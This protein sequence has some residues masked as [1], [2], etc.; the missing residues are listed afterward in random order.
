MMLAVSLAYGGAA[1]GI[2][3]LPAD[4]L[5]PMSAR[6]LPLALAALGLLLGLALCVRGLDVERDVLRNVSVA[7][8]VRAAGLLGLCVL[9][10]LAIEPL[11][12][13]PGGCLAVV[14]GLLLLGER[15]PA[16]LLGLPI[17]A[18]GLLWLVLEG[19][20]DVHLLRGT[21]WQ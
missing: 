15:R 5:E 13:V 7:S 16:V 9:Y 8:S 20:L 17:A 19:L 6:T 11:G 10:G 1:L 14:C 12:F 3:V 2:P 21:L 18:L 4:A